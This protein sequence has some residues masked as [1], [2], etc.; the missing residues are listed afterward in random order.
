M[1]KLKRQNFTPGRVKSVAICLILA[2]VMLFGQ[3][4]QVSAAGSNSSQSDTDSV[5][6]VAMIIDVS[7]SM[8]S[9][10]P[11]HNAT[12]GAKLFVDMAMLNDSQV[13]LITYGFTAKDLGTYT[14]DSQANKNAL[15][16]EIGKIQYPAKG[17]KNGTDTGEALKL[18]QKKL[19]GLKDNGHQKCIIL[20]TDGDV[21]YVTDHSKGS[22]DNQKKTDQQS[23]EECK[24][25]ARW[26]NPSEFDCPLYVLGLNAKVKGKN[27]ISNKGK[28]LIGTL[29]ATSG[30]KSK[31]VTN[32]D[33][34][35]SF[36]TGIFGE[37]TQAE[38][39][40]QPT[41][42]AT[43]KWQSVKID[44]PNSSVE[45]ANIIMM[46]TP[47]DAKDAGN[48]SLI[49]D[50]KLFQPPKAG[51]DQGEEK[52]CNSTDCVLSREPTYCMIALT[53]PEKGE[54]TLQFKADK[55]TKIIPNFFFLY[56]DMVSVHT[57]KAKSG[58]NDNAAIH[59]PVAVECYL[60]SNN[61][62]V[63]D[64]DVYKDIEATVKVIN[65]D[66]D[67]LADEFELTFDDKKMLLVGSFTPEDYGTYTVTTTLKSASF[68]RENGPT[69]VK[70]VAHAPEVKEQIK[71]FSLLIGKSKTLNLSDYFND[72]DGVGLTY[73]FSAE[74]GKLLD[75][76]CDSA[77]GVM[78]MTAK[79]KGDEAFTVTASD[80]SGRKA[81]V[82]FHVKVKSILDLILLIAGI[83]L[84]VAALIAIVIFV[85]SRLKSLN[86]YLHIV[87]YTDST[88]IAYGDDHLSLNN[89]KGSETLLKLMQRYAADV[90]PFNGTLTP[91]LMDGEISSTLSSILLTGT[92][93][94]SCTVT[95]TYKKGL[96]PAS[97]SFSGNDLAGKKQVLTVSDLPGAVPMT[98]T[99]NIEL[100]SGRR[101]D[102]VFQYT[103]T[104]Y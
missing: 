57:V 85:L 12:Q 89:G 74:N 93:G 79:E 43:G 75:A 81:T 92:L 73:Q 101:I 61:T 1:R 98:N 52:V 32:V 21:E 97:V 10:D 20:F 100:P 19:D 63:Q 58:N 64:P 13:V 45:K 15:K 87:S 2:L 66:T 5:F 71:D 47:A 67:E 68:H 62:K 37:I 86:G 91:S 29:A 42:V 4:S 95:L 84:G 83:V 8:N 56:D 9:S 88:G 48:D 16:K 44:I 39:I 22:K 90:E 65:T 103:R 54:W 59:Q 30:G 11:K 27:T 17:A 96:N 72:V 99:L 18:A 49:D 41:I 36:Y 69:E 25:V 38:V 53:R 46:T 78:N 26:G 104:N 80:P 24:E 51:E 102:I 34:I 7:A 82:T 33:Q 77:T 55:G 14:L 6:D 3:V 40:N 35:S 70:V 31:V 50:I 28:D 94:G 23:V 60:K 76:T